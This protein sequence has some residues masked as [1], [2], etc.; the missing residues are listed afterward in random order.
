MVSV[1]QMYEYMYRQASCLHSPV[2]SCFVYSVSMFLCLAVSLSHCSLFASTC[3]S[4]SLPL[5][6][7]GLLS[8]GPVK[9]VQIGSNRLG[10]ARNVGTQAQPS[11]D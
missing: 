11:A 7:S 1:P 9:T 8:Q 4:A 2:L 3:V 10:R 6:P 5:I